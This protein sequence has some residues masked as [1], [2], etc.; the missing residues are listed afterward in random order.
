VVAR[1]GETIIAPV[2]EAGREALRQQLYT[3]GELLRLDQLR[4]DESL[5][6]RD[7]RQLT[8]FVENAGR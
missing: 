4:P 8:L 1:K 7:T 3:P 5:Y 6:E 2:D